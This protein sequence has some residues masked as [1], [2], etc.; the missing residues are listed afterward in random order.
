MAE[1]KVIDLE[2]KTNIGSLKSQL[3]EAQADVAALSEKFGATSQQ[4][5]EAAKRAAELKDRIGD[6]K[7]L[8][9]AFNPDAKFN[10]LSQSIG[11]A[12]NGFQAFEGALGLVGVE[13]ENLQKT[14]LKV[15]SAMA[16]S[17][18][19]QGAMEAKDSFIALGSVVSNAFASMT[20]AAKAFAVTGIGLLVT[21]LGLVVANWDKITGSTSEAI[22]KQKQYQDATKKQ[23]EFIG[24]ESKEFATLITRLKATNQGTK[25]REDLIKKINTQYGTT[26]KNLKDEAAFQNQA[27]AEL[28]AYIEYQKAKFRLQ[29]NEELIAKN[30]ERQSKIRAQLA[31]SEKDEQKAIQERERSGGSNAIMIRRIQHQVELQAELNEELKAAEKRL[32]AYGSAAQ[33]AQV[34]VD[35]I[36]NSGTKFVEQTKKETKA[37]EEF[38]NTSVTA[39]DKSVVDVNNWQEDWNGE[40]KAVNDKRLQDQLD[41]DQS[42]IDAQKQLQQDLTDAA[43]QGAADRVQAAYAEQQQKEAIQK[44]NI[45]F[46]LQGITIVKDL[47]EKSKGVQKAS[48]IAESALGIAKMIISNKT[49]NLGALA[50]PQAIATSGLS[51]A[52]VIA[53]N[54]ITTGL[55]IAANIVATGKALKALGGGGTPPSPTGIGGG[56]TTGGGGQSPSFNVVGNSGI[57]QLAQLQQQPVQAYVVSGQV[58]TAQSLDRNRVENATL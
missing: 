14:L 28:K 42:L 40:L 11:G 38:L 18:G 10:A 44:Q 13:S 3:R 1:T 2:V 50:T 24:N 34:K 35:Q 17:Q 4:A 7:L 56:T 51:A 33:S 26:L 29:A 25:E 37:V 9:D 15:Q 20:T 54:N 5:A 21:A 39:F 41:A 12:L 46:A 43:I 31:Q 47:F 30:L 57:N 6:A 8:T 55:G 22:E 19:I 32:E 45:D 58:T 16:L 48:I 36:T 27:N 23:A 53:A 49:A 52:P